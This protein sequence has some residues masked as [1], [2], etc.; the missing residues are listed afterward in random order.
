MATLIPSIPPEEGKIVHH[1]SNKFIGH[2]CICC[3]KVRWVMLRAKGVPAHTRCASCADKGYGGSSRNWKGGRTVDSK[4]YVYIRVYPD[5]FFYPMVNS[6]GYVAEHRLVVA[7]ALGRNL[8]RWEMVHHKH[9][10]YP[11]GSKEDKADNRFPE[12]LQLVQE[13]QHKQ[14][15][16]LDRRIRL[17]E[18]KV[19]EQ[20]KLIRLLQ[21]Q[22]KTTIKEKI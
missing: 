19:G 22:N 16:L 5:D 1:Y 4:G 20:G 6:N 12:N 21:W 11:A 8:H 15:T 9:A 13:M 18:A 17:L 3:G 2:A 7:K 10:K 14:I